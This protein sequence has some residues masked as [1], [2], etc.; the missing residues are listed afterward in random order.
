MTITSFQ[1][2]SI[3]YAANLNTAFANAV[4]IA[5]DTMTGTLIL[6]T[7]QTTGGV[8]YAN[9]GM[10]TTSIINTVRLNV[11]GMN[12]YSTVTAAFNQANTDLTLAQAAFDK[13][14]TGGGS[15]TETF[16]TANGLTVNTGTSLTISGNATVMLSVNTGNLTQVGVV[17][18]NDTVKSTSTLLAATANA[19]NT[20]WATANAAFIK[21]NSGVA[22]VGTETYI[23]SNGITVNSGTSLITTGNGT[24]LLSANIG[25][26]TQQGIVQLNDTF[27]STSASLAATANVANT[28]WTTAVAAFNKANAGGGAISQTFL[29][30]NGLTVNTGVSFNTSGNASILFAA[31]SANLTQVGVVQL[32]DTVTSTSNT[33]AAT[34]NAVSTAFNTAQGA[35]NAAN[36]GFS[37]LTVTY[38]GGQAVTINNSVQFSQT[39]GGTVAFAANTGT[40]G[41]IGVVQL[42]D[43]VTSQFANQAATA[44]ATNTV[45]ATAQAAFA[46]ANLNGPGVTTTFLTANGLTV[47][48]FVSFSATG[49]TTVVLSANLGNTTQSGVIQLND[50]VTSTSK[51]LGATANAVNTAWATA[52]AAFKVANSFAGGITTT[53]FTQNG[54]QVN[55]GSSLVVVGSGNPLF[56]GIN[57]STTQIGVVQL[58]DTLT[59]TS[60]TQAATA[61]AVNAAIFVANN[62]VIRSGDTM[63]GSLVINNN[64][65]VSQTLTVTGNSFLNGSTIS[66]NGT[67]TLGTQA[68]TKG[69]LG[70]VVYAS[71]NTTNTGDT[72]VATNILYRRAT[73]NAS[74][75][76]TSDGQNPRATPYGTINFIT[77]SNNSVYVFKGHVAGRDTNTNVTKVWAV[78]GVVKRGLGPASTQFVTGSPIINVIADDDPL[79]AG[80]LLSVSVDTANGGIKIA[81]S[82]VANTTNWL[83]KID[84]IE[85]G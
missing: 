41:Q 78:E 82:N 17:Q 34:A 19:V 46:K 49:N 57:A 15:L 72:Q 64:L 32:N 7:F 39:G 3:L 79:T 52:N 38:V 76:L 36:A 1:P 85:L 59:S 70:R 42:N 43:T 66:S 27:V 9:G 35:F 13:A 31:N 58:N 80:W 81:T 84:T 5:G 83:S 29:T 22:S 48:N 18:L 45:W 26:T 62:A 28:I 54:I 53:Y 6:P 63:S 14:N 11:A 51:V 44:N 69:T 4:N 71:G 60:T 55:L 33:L 25:N 10:N 2:G 50:T 8:S 75:V 16:I 61:N 37:G 40:T 23:S 20:V 24:V 68:N 21:A 65:N 67:V 77:L 12:V 73:S 30:Q 47:N 56:S 74:F